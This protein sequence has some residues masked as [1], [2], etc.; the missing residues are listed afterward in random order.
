MK[1]TIESYNQKYSIY[2]NDEFI[3][4]FNRERFM[5]GLENIFFVPGDTGKDPRYGR[6]TSKFEA[7]EI[8]VNG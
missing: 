4:E 8:S 1:T 7:Q 3:Y 6:R 2:K 5:R